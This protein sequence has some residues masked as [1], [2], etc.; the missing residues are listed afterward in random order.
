M[1]EDH[2]YLIIVVLTYCKI[3]TEVG[4]ITTVI[5][6]TFLLKSQVHKRPL[7]NGFRPTI[8]DLY[9]DGGGG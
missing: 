7:T 8:A 2:W 6:I 4:W 5:N 9:R 1:L 3:V